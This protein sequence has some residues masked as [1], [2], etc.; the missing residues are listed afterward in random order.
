MDRSAQPYVAVRRVVTM[1]TI[2]E[3]ADRIPELLD[4]VP[5]H[6]GRQA[7]AAFLKYNVI[8]MARALEVEA[9][10]PVAAPIGGA[11]LV[12]AGTLPAGR[13]VVFSH[14]G[15]PDELVE[16]TGGVLDWAQRHGL[17]WDVR[18]TPAGQRWGCRLE[19]YHSDPV[20]QPDLHQW[21][22]DLVFRLAG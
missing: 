6:G 7:G 11:G 13:F 16:V 21:D 20:E 12:F 2:G 22:T 4:W 14:H 8:D 9:G 15:H 1:S 5:A 19:V 3:I 17:C 18:D 10:V